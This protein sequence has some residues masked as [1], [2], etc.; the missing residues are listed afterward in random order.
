MQTDWNQADLC[1]DEQ[2]QSQNIRRSMTCGVGYRAISTNQAV[3][4]IT[5][6]FSALETS[7]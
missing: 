1:G 2:E 6:A 5:T 4:G 7:E 3:C